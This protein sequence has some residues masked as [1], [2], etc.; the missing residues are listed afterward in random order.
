MQ[1]ECDVNRISQL[2][3]EELHKL[4]YGV[5]QLDTEGN[6]VF[7]SDYESRLSRLP[8]ERVVG[9]NFFTEIA[10]CTD[11]KEF[12]GQFLE[13]VAKRELHVRFHFHFPFKVNPQTVL[14]TLFYSS[15]TENVWVLVQPTEGDT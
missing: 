9:K 1:P 4:P 14:V 12:R 5:I 11:V 7:Y 6:V 15:I 8:R 10:P 3:S 13:G 2:S